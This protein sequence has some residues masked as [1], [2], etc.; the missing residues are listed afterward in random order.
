MLPKLKSA[1][2]HWEPRSETI[3]IHA[4]VHPWLPLLKEKLEPLFAPIRYKP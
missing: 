4:W 3:P 2:D 1:V